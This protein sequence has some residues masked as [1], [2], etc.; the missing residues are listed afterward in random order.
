MVSSSSQH[1]D[2]PSGVGM[3]E[4]SWRQTVRS[5]V[6]VCLLWQ[7]SWRCPR[8]GWSHA[9]QLQALSRMRLGP[10]SS[11]SVFSGSE[12]AAE[13]P[14][15]PPRH[16]RPARSA[17]SGGHASQEAGA[18]GALFAALQERRGERAFSQEPQEWQGVRLRCAA[19]AGAQADGG[20]D[21]QRA[22]HASL[23]RAAIAAPAV[24]SGVSPQETCRR[25]SPD[26][27]YPGGR[28]C[29]ARPHEASQ[30]GWQ[31]LASAAH[32]REHGLPVPRQSQWL[33][34]TSIGEHWSAGVSD[35]AQDAGRWRGERSAA[36]QGCIEAWHFDWQGD[37]RR[38]TTCRR[39]WFSRRRKYIS[40]S[41]SRKAPTR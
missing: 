22:P 12:E 24:G 16:R 33:H 38:D 26:S 41:R 34:G 30:L 21:L 18:P 3:S 29:S 13:Q 23:P 32:A 8:W 9:F 35:E 7:P 14:A 17:R 10:T 27:A 37:I 40:D 4:G 39:S 11:S 19:S 25:C 5:M 28:R 2:T 1:M 15:E 6:C 20:G 31:F 36:P